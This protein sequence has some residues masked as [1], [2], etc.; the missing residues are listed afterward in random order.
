MNQQRDEPLQPDTVTDWAE[1]GRQQGSRWG[2]EFSG[3]AQ[4]WG[5][6]AWSWS[7]PSERPP[8]PWW[9][10]LFWQIAGLPLFV[11]GSALLLAL[12]L[13]GAAGAIVGGALL[14]WL[15]SGAGGAALAARS[16]WPGQIGALFG[17]LLG[18]IGL[19]IVRRLPERR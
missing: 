14:V 11:L 7:H 10:R 16:G 6:E 5:S 3:R 15:A 1:W 19:L 4:G 17:F 9:S 8:G 18:P 12:I 2:K 13:V